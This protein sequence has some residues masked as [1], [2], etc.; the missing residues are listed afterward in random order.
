MDTLSVLLG[1]VSRPHSFMDVWK[2]SPNL[3]PPLSVPPCVCVTQNVVSVRQILASC[4]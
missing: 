4:S 1:Q 3:R 2:I